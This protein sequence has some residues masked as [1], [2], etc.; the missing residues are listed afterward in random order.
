LPNTPLVGLGALVNEANALAPELNG[1]VKQLFQ[2]FLLH[3]LKLREEKKKKRKRKE[4]NEI[5]SK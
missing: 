3:F 4:K 1:L 5:R 2:L